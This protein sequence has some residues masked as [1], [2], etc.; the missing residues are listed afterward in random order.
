MIEVSS[1]NTMSLHVE[2][3]TSPRESLSV[4]PRT[5]LLE[6]E[7]WEVPLRSEER[8]SKEEETEQFMAPPTNNPNQS[9]Y[10][11]VESSNSV[12]YVLWLEG[13]QILMLDQY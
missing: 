12:G 1:D 6:K 9:Q 8:E 11:L 3:K 5:V 2:V 4:S 7:L 10:Y 13:N